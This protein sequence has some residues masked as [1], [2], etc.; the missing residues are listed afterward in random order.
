MREGRPGYAV[1][2]ARENCYEVFW[3][4]TQSAAGERC[5]SMNKHDMVA[6][7]FRIAGLSQR[8]AA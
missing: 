5:A 7:S 4:L 2:D 1:V 6:A 3:F 8:R